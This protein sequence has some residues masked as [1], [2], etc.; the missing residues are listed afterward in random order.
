M[1]K[2]MFIASWQKIYDTLCEAGCPEDMAAEIANER[3][4]EHMREV[5]FDMG[6]AERLRRKER[7]P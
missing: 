4:Y 3:A 1:S 2:E 6:D 5:M 7:A